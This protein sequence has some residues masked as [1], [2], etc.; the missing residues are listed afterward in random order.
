M[1]QAKTAF[2]R[3][4]D[5][6]LQSL[7]CEIQTLMRKDVLQSVPLKRFSITITSITNKA[8]HFLEVVSRNKT[9]LEIGGTAKK[10]NEI[11]LDKAKA[12]L[13]KKT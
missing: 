11:T 10:I 2:R 1:K 3:A 8:N 6:M 7:A 5:S 9:N 4:S 13:L 12:K